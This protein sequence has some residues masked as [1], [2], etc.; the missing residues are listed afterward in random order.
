VGLREDD[1][2]ADSRRVQVRRCRRLRDV[3]GMTMSWAWGGRRCCRPGESV[4][5]RH[6]RLRED[7]GAMSL[8]TV[9]VDGI[10]GSGC[11]MLLQAQEQCRGLWDGTCMVDGVTSLGRGRWRRVKWLDRGQE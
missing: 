11:M 9:R 1:G 3:V 4:G 8:G 10:R 7:D 5:R 6:H 2:V